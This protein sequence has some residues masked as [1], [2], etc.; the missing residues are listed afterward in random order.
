[1]VYGKEPVKY[2]LT[3]TEWD[4]TVD[5]I[6][7]ILIQ[8]AKLRT[9]ITYGELAAQL[10]TIRP[11]PGAYVFHALLRD[12]CHEE[13]QLGRGMLC[14]VVVTK[15]TGIP[16]QGFFKAMIKNERDC[17]HPKQCWKAEIERLYAIWDK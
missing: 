4:A 7:G 3:A 16:G 1:M 8:I 5:E 6:R 11:H 2:G 13:E 12:I 15:A 14:A 17:R 9:T 10:T